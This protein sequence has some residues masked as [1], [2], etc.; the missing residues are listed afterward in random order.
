[1]TRTRTRSQ[2]Y[3]IVCREDTLCTS[4]EGKQSL[5]W[6]RSPESFEV[7]PVE[8]RSSMALLG[9]AQFASDIELL[10]FGALLSGRFSS[11]I[12]LQRQ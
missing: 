4:R 5:L 11:V 2:A 10:V 12:R 9:G 3:C 1:M 6:Q 8:S 7:C